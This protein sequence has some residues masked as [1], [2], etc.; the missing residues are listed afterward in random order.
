MPHVYDDAWDQKA[1]NMVTQGG[2]RRFFEYMKLFKLEAEPNL[3]I[4]Y[5]SDIAVYYRKWLFDLVFGSKE[6]H[7]HHY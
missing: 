1:I 5:G 4:K 3:D 6:L 7:H 2:N